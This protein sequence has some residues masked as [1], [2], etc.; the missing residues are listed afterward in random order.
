M[1]LDDSTDA[2]RLLAAAAQRLEAAG[3][4]DAAGYARQAIADLASAGGEDAVTLVERLTTVVAGLTRRAA[5]EEA[6]PLAIEVQDLASRRLPHDHPALTEI[7]RILGHVDLALGDVSAARSAFEQAVELRR[8]A[9]GEQHIDYVAALLELGQF[10]DRSNRHEEA[11]AILGR[12]LELVTEAGLE[13]DALRGEFV[14]G[15]SLVALADAHRA[16]GDLADAERLYRDAITFYRTFPHVSAEREHELIARVANVRSQHGDYEEAKDLYREAL[17]AKELLLGTENPDYAGTLRELAETQAAA[18]DF[19]AAASTF[20]EALGIQLA[21]LGN[22]HPT[23]GATLDAM[24]ELRRAEGR[25]SE[26]AALYE[27]AL[28]LYRQSSRPTE[29]LEARSLHHLGAVAMQRGDGARAEALLT[30]SL[31][32]SQA[33]LG[34][35]HVQYAP[36]LEALA[37]LHTDA[38]DYAAAEPLFRDAVR[39]TRNAY[40]DSPRLAAALDNLA[41][42][43]DELGDYSEA[44]RLYREALQLRRT[45]LPAAHRDLAITL[46][47]L[48]GVRSRLGEYAEARDLL[49]EALRVVEQSLGKAHPRYGGMLV[50][51]AELYRAS[52][53]LERAVPLMREAL[54]NHRQ[55]LGEHHPETA[56]PLN[57]LAALYEQSGSPEAAEPLYVEALEISR[58]AV[59]ETHQRYAS[60]ASNLAGLY[61]A[62]GRAHEALAL[63]MSVET[64]RDVLLGNAFAIGSERRRMA[65]LASVDGEFHTFL[66]LVVDY[67]AA[68]PKAVAAALDLVLRRKAIG[69]EAL[70]VQRDAVLGGRYPHLADRLRELTEL[71]RRIAETMLSSPVDDDLV[72]HSELLAR[73]QAGR[74]ELEGTLAGQIPEMNLAGRLRAASTSAIAEALPARAALVEIVQTDIFDFTADRTRGEGLWKA[75][76]Y[77]AFVVRSGDPSPSL[78]DLGETERIDRHVAAYRTAVTGEPDPGAR[79]TTAP[80][81]PSAKADATPARA[82]RGAVTEAARDVTA[83]ERRVPRGDHLELG[84]TLRRVIFDPIAPELEEVGHVFVSTDGEL[85]RV[86]LQALPLADDRSLLDRYEFTYLAVGRDLIRIDAFAPGQREAS[87]VAA[88]PDFDLAADA[89]QEASGP[90]RPL[91]GTRREGEI[92][93]DLLS[94][95]LLTGADVLESVLKTRPSPRV[96]HLATHGF[97][98]PDEAPERGAKRGDLPGPASATGTVSPL[99][100]LAA[101]R[102]V[103]PLLRSGLA[104]AGANTWLAGHATPRPAEDGLLTAEDVTGLDLIGTELAVL[105]ACETGLGQIHA[106]EG[107]FGLR[108]AFELAGARTLVM[109]LWKVPDDATQ[110]LMADFYER[111]LGGA[112]RSHALRQAQIAARDRDPHPYAWGGFVCQGDPGPLS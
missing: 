7:V 59:G 9:V 61:A 17:N 103:N 3:K 55:S 49:N 83:G 4:Q 68:D 65:Y 37:I 12:S 5:P 112:G 60:I 73:L 40:G 80:D 56:I 89:R 54:D 62:T 78:V 86:P 91:P 84:R 105:S 100:R 82:F 99:G 20:E 74:E 10:L 23:V 93:A 104:L 30:Q 42:F 107:V 31:E 111:V 95:P 101:R 92:V 26:A 24:G 15:V 1:T 32:L 81:A 110:A 76:R 87:V 77:L 71:R 72:A 94:V 58:A 39:I 45:T 14:L 108:R 97:F 41:Q 98:L 51:L 88:D 85:L 34:P 6:R 90:F 19:A 52:G 35:D 106:G 43:H 11:V 102:L 70:A 67:L 33:A 21:V 2:V 38:G 69:A 8:A 46:H 109:S 25:F 36:T 57:G 53:Q 44:E 29:L 50:A 64:A 96:L 28:D 79:S 63:R 66:S 13:D 22:G 47:N 27:Q 75:A 48:A 18:G 16:R